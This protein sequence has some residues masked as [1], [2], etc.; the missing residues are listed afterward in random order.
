MCRTNSIGLILSLFFLTTFVTQAEAVVE[1]K[2]K[3]NDKSGFRDSRAL[4]SWYPK[5]IYFEENHAKPKGQ[6]RI[7]FEKGYAIDELGQFNLAPGIIWEMLP[8]GQLFGKF[9]KNQKSGYKQIS[10]RKYNCSMTVKEILAVKNGASEQPKETKA[11]NQAPPKPQ[12]NK[13]DKAKKECADLG[14]K[15]GTEKHGDCVLRILDTF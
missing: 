15:T 12:L 4:D 13:L 11:S 1:C 3:S 8:N 14:F 9:A 2:R 10:P 7:T 6:K 5:L